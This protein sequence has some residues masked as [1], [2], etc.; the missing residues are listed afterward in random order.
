MS[1]NGFSIGIAVAAY[2]WITAMALTSLQQF[3]L[4]R[5]T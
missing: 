1:G 4:Y 5:F 2:E 3:G